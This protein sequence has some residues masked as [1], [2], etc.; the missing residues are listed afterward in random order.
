[1]L[2]EAGEVVVYWS[3]RIACT[4][5]ISRRNRGFEMANPALEIGILAP[6]FATLDRTARIVA[7]LVVIAPE[8]VVPE[9]AWGVQHPT[10]MTALGR[11]E[12]AARFTALAGGTR[13]RCL[14]AF[15]LHRMCGGKDMSER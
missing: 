11:D 12:L 1:M 4:G 7:V 5:L 13:Y 15:A 14:V 8:V 2:V 10:S 3:L 9:R 6:S